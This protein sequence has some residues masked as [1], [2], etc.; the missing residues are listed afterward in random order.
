MVRGQKDSGVSNIVSRVDDM[1]ELAVRLG[2]VSTFDRRG[3]VIFADDFEEPVFKW[4]GMV[5][6]SGSMRLDSSY[7]NS[8]A[9]C[10]ELTTSASIGHTRGIARQIG[11]QENQ[12]IGLEVAFCN[13]PVGSELHLQINRDNGVDTYRGEVYVDFTTNQLFLFNSTGA[14]QLIASLVPFY[15][16]SYTYYFF[17]LVVDFDLLTY[18][19]VF[20]FNQ[21]FDI[22]DYALRNI[23]ST[24]GGFMAFQIHLVTLANAAK[25]IYL[26][27]A[28]I[29][30]EE[31]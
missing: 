5:V 19:R 22:S 2:S 10:V 30:Q 3:H 17:K 26:D 31:P 21:W 9:Q 14:Y 12:S 23:G 11:L 15:S 1:G 27:D 20:L 6:G 8:G 18:K 16:L 13:P 7:P 29:T 4:V 28:I 25:T 24:V